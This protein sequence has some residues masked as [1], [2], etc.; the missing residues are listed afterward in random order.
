M[1][2]QFFDENTWLYPD[3]VLPASEQAPP[4]LFLAR[5]GHAGLQI[6]TDWVLPENTAVRFSFCAAEGLEAEL[7]QL[8][9]ARVEHNSGAKIL[10]ADSY[11]EVSGFVTRQAP[12]DVYDITLPVEGG[13]L[14]PGRA[15]FFLRFFARGDLP[16]REAKMQI[17]LTAGGFSL[18]RTLSLCVT[19]ARVPALQ[20]TGFAINNW[21][22][23]PELAAAYGL[24]TDDP[25]FWNLVDAYLDN[26]QELRCNH[27]LLPSGEPVRGSDGTVTGF[28]FSLCIKMGEHA[29]K[30]GFAFLYGGF[31]ARFHVW[32]E[33]EH[34]LLWDTDVSATSLEGYRQLKLY[35]TALRQAVQEHGWAGHWMQ[36]LVD[37]PQFP[38]SLTYRALSAICRKLMPGVLINDPVETTDVP[39]G[40]D[41]WCVKQSV[42]DQYR[43]V[44]KELQRMGET[45]T[46]Y[47]CGF[48]A[49]R[50]MNR[51]TDLPLAAGRLV[52]WMC[53][54]ENFAG[55]LHW[56][57]NAYNGMNPW[58]ESCYR[59]GSVLYPPGNSFIV[60]PGKKGPVNSLRAQLQ[61]FGAEDCELLRQLPEKRR[62]ELTSRLCSDFEHY[63]TDPACFARV[64]RELLLS[65]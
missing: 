53:A 27:I 7:Y 40:M 38:N 25:V 39:G 44:F 8:R 9:P 30:K 59:D 10:T 1:G 58:K 45:L 35:F 24:Q 61:L 23:L 50:W 47:T 63:E 22:K 60:Y 37:E 48:P 42:F 36:C 31:V 29:R 55:F 54:K 32:N 13:V 26:Q 11:E 17:C 15:A 2:I 12:F 65:F 20:E 33:P 56:G 5:G 14:Q 18:E 43:P 41:I 28:D 21:L 3:T 62:E 49:G 16:P 57:Y 52:F 4:A 34:Y 6:L 19:N 51:A 64:H 46:V